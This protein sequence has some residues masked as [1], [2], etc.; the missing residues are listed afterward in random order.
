MKNATKALLV[1]GIT[2]P[3]CGIIATPVG[4]PF[5]MILIG[6]AG[7]LVTFFAS[8]WM[9]SRRSLATLSSRRQTLFCGVISAGITIPL[10]IVWP[11][12]DFAPRIIPGLAATG[13]TFSILRWLLSPRAETSWSSDH[14]P[15]LCGI[16]SACVTLTLYVLFQ[17]ALR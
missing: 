1:A 9:L 12:C 3:L 8:W 7:A 13:F 15:L 4:D 6:L 11:F 17:I 2:F 10:L 5:T 14:Q 16:I